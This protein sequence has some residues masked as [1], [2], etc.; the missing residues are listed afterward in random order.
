[1]SDN[2]KYYYL[3][4]KENFYDTEEIKI[5]ENMPN[6]YKYS[7]I[8]LKLYLKSLKYNGALRVNEYIP[9]NAEMIAA[10]TGHDVDTVRIAMSIFK[11]LKLIEV[12]ENGTIYMLDIQ[13][14]IGKTSTEADRIRT[15]RTQ[16]EKEKQL[17]E[18]NVQNQ[19]KCTPE[20][21]K[22]IESDINKD[23]DNIVHQDAQ[24]EPKKP[25]KKE[26]S[27]EIKQQAESLW[28]LYP[29]KKGKSTAIK[30][31]PKL[32]KEYSLEQLKT[33]IE[34]YIQY[35]EHTRKTDFKELKYQNGST[36]FNG[37]F[38]DYLDEN[39]KEGCNGA[40]EK[41]SEYDPSKDP[42]FTRRKF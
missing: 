2:K 15:Y 26:L 7:N 17:T 38:E 34:R 16:I 6:G 5:L 28:K 27:E 39:W 12:M 42:L 9:Y 40:T 41:H 13:S 25:N 4:L 31:I 1:M 10:V 18:G 14:F 8:L 36:F 35:V 22:E 21:K 19:Y 37:T 20:L 24:R 32:L 33:C 3:R 29:Y 23:K 11:K 30:K